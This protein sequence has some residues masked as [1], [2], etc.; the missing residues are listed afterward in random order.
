LA[1]FSS[2]LS[3]SRCSLRIALRLS[4]ILLRD[5]GNMQQPVGAGEDLDKR[6]EI[7]DPDHLAQ[8][9]L[10]HLGHRSDIGDHLDAAVR[11]R[12]KTGS[13]GHDF[14]ERASGFTN[15]RQSQPWLGVR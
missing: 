9:G 8:I 12:A 5:L 6:A 2:F 10:A 14:R 15:L 1:T 11:G 3:F 7:D 4:L 13:Q